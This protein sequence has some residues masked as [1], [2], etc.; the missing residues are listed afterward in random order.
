MATHIQTCNLEFDRNQ[1]SKLFFAF[2]ICAVE[3]NTTRPQV[4]LQQVTAILQND[5]RV[6]WAELQNIAFGLMYHNIEDIEILRAFVCNV[7][8]RTKPVPVY[9]YKS[10]KFMRYYLKALSLDEELWNFTYYDNICYHAENDFNIM[11]MENASKK[12]EYANVNKVL[13]G[14]LGI[15]T[16]FWVEWENLFILDFCLL[17]HKVAILIKM[18][19]DYIDYDKQYELPLIAL[20]E[21]ILKD[22]FWEVLV[23]DYH[24]INKMGNEKYEELK[25]EI[26]L[27]YEATQ[28]TWGNPEDM[29]R[30]KN[31]MRVLKMKAMLANTRYLE[32]WKKDNLDAWVPTVDEDPD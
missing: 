29:E 14:E 11:R 28:K 24:D 2:S 31:M 6:N 7:S 21:K 19:N 20:K 9:Y 10:I 32:N 5:K 23:Y 8:F 16:K 26:T 18:E 27:A 12:A 15:D 17:P 3:K 25:K 1:T 4:L 30:N 22:H 13:R